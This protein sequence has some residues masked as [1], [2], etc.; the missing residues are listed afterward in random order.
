M[1]SNALVNKANV[2]A[3]L[4]E[5]NQSQDCFT[6]ALKVDPGC[7]DV[8]IHRARVCTCMLLVYAHC[9]L[10][11]V[12][13]LTGQLCIAYQNITKLTD[14]SVNLVMFWYGSL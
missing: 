13:K 11:R 6:Q 9:V 2:L 8:Y 3:G 12:H 7:T 14:W 4:Q 1:Y 10:I 5:V